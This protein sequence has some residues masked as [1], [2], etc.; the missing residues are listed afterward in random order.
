[1]TEAIRRSGGVTDRADR[2]RIFVVR[3]DGSVVAGAGFQGTYWDHQQRRWVRVSLDRIVLMEGDSV[4]VPPDL[5]YN[6]TGLLLAQSLSTTFFQIASAA[7][8]VA[9]L[10]TRL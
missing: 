5:E 6:P 10:A 7:A 1:M 8:T 3:A 4:V 2:H 9:V